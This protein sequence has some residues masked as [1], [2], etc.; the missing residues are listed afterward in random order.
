M[1]TKIFSI[2]VFAMTSIM[3]TAWA[4]DVTGKWVGKADKVDITLT[5]KG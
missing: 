3:T 2:L 4:V 1:R 5:L